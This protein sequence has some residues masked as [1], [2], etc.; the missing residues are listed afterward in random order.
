MTG[1]IGRPLW[2]AGRGWEA[3][4]ESREGSGGRQ[5]MG[6]PSVGWEG[7]EGHPREPG[8]TRRGW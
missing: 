1:R 6:N 7:S 5:R 8:G 4:P 3:L 2:R